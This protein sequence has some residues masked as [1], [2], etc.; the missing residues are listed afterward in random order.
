MNKCQHEPGW[1]MRVV[2]DEQFADFYHYVYR[3]E[4]CG[5]LIEMGIERKDGKVYRTWVVYELAGAA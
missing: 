3:C 2:E 5:E 4:K 1:N